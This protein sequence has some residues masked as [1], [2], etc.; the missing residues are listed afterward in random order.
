MAKRKVTSYRPKAKPKSNRFN[1]W[2]YTGLVSAGLAAAGL[3][4]QANKSNQIAVNDKNYTSI[5]QSLENKVESQALVETRNDY[6][7]RQEY[8]D[9][10]LRGITIPYCSG[11]V[12][13]HDGTKIIEYIRSELIEAG[14]SKEDITL[15]LNEYK[16]SFSDGDYDAKVPK[17]LQLAA[18]NRASKIFIGRK[19]F[20]EYSLLDSDVRNILY[21]E[22]RHAVQ[23]AKGS[24]FIPN[25][26]LIEAINNKQIDLRVFYEIEELDAN[27]HAINEVL[28]GKERV[29]KPYFMNNRLRNYIGNRL[30]LQEAEEKSSNLQKLFIRRAFEKVGVLDTKRISYVKFIGAAK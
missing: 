18:M 13:D 26:Q 20:E 14:A 11:V 1:R 27:F 28:S 9:N 2:I 29:S 5:T 12:Y 16:D 23:Q 7:K 3:V 8:L 4:Y 6:T 30:F 24:D 25:G 17:L 19:L 22:G 10:L 21:H 15:H